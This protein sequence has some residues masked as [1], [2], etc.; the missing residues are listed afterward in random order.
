MSLR[1]S[2]KVNLRCS[3]SA[4]HLSHLAKMAKIRTQ[5]KIEER[6][7]LDMEESKQQYQLMSSLRQSRITDQS[8][9]LKGIRASFDPLQMI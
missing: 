9:F 2:V 7:G 8:K 5:G 1:T 6:K 3:E 4:L